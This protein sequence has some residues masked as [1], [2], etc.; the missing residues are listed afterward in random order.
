MIE[1]LP[2]TKNYVHGY[3]SMESRL[4]KI[5]QILYDVYRYLID[6]TDFKKMVECGLN[7]VE[8]LRY[9]YDQF[10]DEYLL[11]LVDLDNPDPS[12]VE[13]WYHLMTQTEFYN[14]WSTE[15]FNFIRNE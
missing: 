3:F 1:K 9:V 11:E 2:N 8:D 10:L 12:L 14:I 7:S 4:D 5:N 6:Q 15:L 13:E